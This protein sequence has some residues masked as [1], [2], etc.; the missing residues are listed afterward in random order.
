MAIVSSQGWVHAVAM[1]LALPI[2]GS[3]EEDG[4]CCCPHRA[5]LGM[6]TDLQG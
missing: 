3:S 5:G 4:A 6:V 1:G 2:A